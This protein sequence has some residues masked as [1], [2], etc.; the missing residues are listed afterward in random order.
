MVLILI[1]NLDVK[2]GHCNGTRYLAVAFIPNLI[3]AK[4]LSDG[5]T[6]C[7]Y[8]TPSISKYS[9]FP[10]SF[11]R[12]QFPVFIAYYM[13]INRAQGQT[14]MRSGVCLLHSI[15]VTGTTTL[16][17]EETEI[18]MRPFV[19]LTRENLTTSKKSLTQRSL[20]Q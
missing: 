16:H 12:I 7:I 13:T 9:S 8:R 17:L 15:F 11:K 5:E 14:L 4:R 19:M 20:T 1:Q 10:V 3:T 18:M 2:E 6:L